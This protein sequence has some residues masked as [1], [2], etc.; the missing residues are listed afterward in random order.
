M[1]INPARVASV[2]KAALAILCCVIIG[3]GLFYVAVPYLGTKANITF[4]KVPS[5]GLQVENQAPEIHG[6][7]IE[8]TNF[9]L[10]DYRGKVVMLDFWAHW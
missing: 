9:K 2:A 3:V 6:N 4:G 1:L 10:S 5:I 8:G 7:D